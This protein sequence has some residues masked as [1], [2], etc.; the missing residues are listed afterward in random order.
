[1]HTDKDFHVTK[2]GKNIENLYAIGS[3]LSGHNSI[4]HADGTGFIIHLTLI[5]L[6][7]PFR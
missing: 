2:D 7:S 6:M 3:V 1:M 5:L 4:K